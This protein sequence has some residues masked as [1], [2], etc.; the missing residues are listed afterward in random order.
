MPGSLERWCGIKNRHFGILRK[1]LVF[2][3]RLVCE[4]CTKSFFSLEMRRVFE[5]A[6]CLIFC[7]R[8]K[9]K[10]LLA[11]FWKLHLFD[12]I[13]SKST[14]QFNGRMQ[15]LLFC[16][17]TSLKTNFLKLIS[18]SWEAKVTVLYTNRKRSFLN[19]SQH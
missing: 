13:L 14:F 3:N 6:R 15:W 2:R 18:Y 12:R 5:I 4:N 17:Q 10:F 9:N 1:L 7:F 19:I 8:I 16:F 11:K